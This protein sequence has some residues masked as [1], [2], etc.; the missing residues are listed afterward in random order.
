M[1]TAP[2]SSWTFL[3]GFGKTVLVGSEHGVLISQKGTAQ[4]LVEGN[5]ITK[6]G[7][8]FL[9]ALFQWGILMERQTNVCLQVSLTHLEVLNRYV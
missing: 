8:A 2:L 6:S 7:A 9:V 5:L 1:Q 3:F 4:F